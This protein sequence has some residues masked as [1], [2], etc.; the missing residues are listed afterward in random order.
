[1][2]DYDVVI[3]GAGLAGF[4][5][6]AEAGDQGLKTLLVEKGKTTGGTGNYVEGV[7]AADSVIQKQ[8]DAVIDK[9]ELLQE[10]LNYSHYRADGRMWQKYIDQAGTNV[11]WLEERGAKITMVAGLGDGA[12]TWHLFEGKGHD[13]I[14]N[15]LEPY[16]KEKGVKLVT[17]TRVIDL[18]QETDNSYEVTLLQMIDEKERVVKAKNI[19]L[20]TGGYLNDQ[21]L[22]AST[23]HQNPQNIIP[24]NSG[25][26]TG[27]GLRLA[28]NL[29]AKKF[30]TGMAMMFGGQLKDPTIPAYKLWGTA[31]WSSVCDQPQ[32]WV[33][34]MGERFVDESAAVVNWAN[35]GNA[36][37]RQDRI[38]CIFSQKILDDF[39]DKSYPRSMK[40]FVPEDRYPTLR[41]DIEQ[42]EKDGREYLHKANTL[43]EL[44]E[45]IDTP[46]LVSYVKHYNEMAANG[47]DTDFHKPAKYLLPVDGNGPFYAIELGV[48]AYTTGDGLRVNVNNQVLDTE[49]RLIRG[50]YAIGGDGSAV[51]Y[52]DTY[53]V[54]VPGTHAGYCVFS[55]RNAIQS[56]VNK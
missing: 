30:F 37:N 19:V 31:I 10:E 50:L 47:E 17:Q 49:G 33:N 54:N 15:G 36:M 40:P 16:A 4:A 51:L 6:A 1:M 35:E 56:I 43:E 20:A 38:F 8:E 5:A 53:G 18:K 24:V 52:G 21:E 13:A 12:K 39:T 45:E 26:N 3:V 55:G 23:A 46:N 9:K 42:A 22:L 32:C 7:F 41:D 2:E 34:E 27:D 44:A 11:S 25:K 14:H 28:W 48:G 29:G